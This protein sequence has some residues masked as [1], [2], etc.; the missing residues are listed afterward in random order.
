MSNRVDNANLRAT[1]GDLPRQVADKIARRCWSVSR[2]DLRQEAEVVALR[3]V[4]HHDPDKGDLRGY[5]YGA[6]S[7]ALINYVYEA[8]S[9]VS[10]KHRRAELKD[11]RGSELKETSAV[12]EDGGDRPA[13]A[14]WRVRVVARAAELAGADAPAVIPCLFEDASPMEASV[15]T[16]VP[17]GRVLAAVG[18]TRDAIC[19]DPVM[20]QLHEEGP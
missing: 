5:L 7:R 3:A 6:V 19:E 13:I 1:V 16:G 8:G 17:L 2:A 12:D 18:R 9:P 10:Y 20:R 4:E 11:T 14:I 15:R